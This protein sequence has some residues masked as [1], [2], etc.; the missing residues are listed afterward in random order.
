MKEITK[1]FSLALDWQPNDRAIGIVQP[2]QIGSGRRATTYT[3]DFETRHTTRKTLQLRELLALPQPVGLMVDWK[4]ASKSPN[5]LA[6]VIAQSLR[7][8]GGVIVLAAKLDYCWTIAELL[9]TQSNRIT[10]PSPEV[11]MVQK[12][13]TDEFAADFPLIEL[14]KYGVAVHHRGL[15]DEALR[16]IEW[17]F[18]K[19]DIK[20]L[21]AT[22]TVAQGM[23]FPV[24]SVVMASHQYFG[25]GYAVDMPPED[26]WNVAGRAGRV[27]QGSVGIVAFAATKDDKA[28]KLREFI[29]GEV[30]ALNST[31][32]A[33]VQEAMEKW[34][35][36]NLD[37][38]LFKE[39]KW[40]SFLQYLAHS[41]RQM[42]N[43]QEF[44]NRIEQILRGTLGFNTLR[45][46]HRGWA[47]KLISGVRV[48]A[49]R[50]AG[51]PLLLVDQTGFSLESVRLAMGKLHEME[52]GP[53]AW[54]GQQLF[55]RVSEDL[56]QMM[57][58]L[59]GVPELREGF[60]KLLHG[61]LQDG[62][63]LS[64][65][66]SDWVNG[67]SMVK[68]AEVYF[69]QG[70][71]ST[72][73]TRNKAYQ[74]CCRNVYGQLAQT[75]SWGLSALQTI[76]LAGKT[77]GMTEDQLARMRNIP[78]WV[79][80]GVNTDGALAMRMAG[81][82]REAATKLSR[83]IPTGKVSISG[84]REQLMSE[85]GAAWTRA[86]GNSGQTYFSIWRQLEGI[87]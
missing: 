86:L 5:K 74:E 84:I 10:T 26:F 35:T 48:Y 41:Y 30:G 44:A 11:V 6:A 71:P 73:E 72:P 7:S 67:A 64:S 18:E 58:V 40:S 61:K 25:S 70:L 14:L 55:T 27:D 17:L 47:D 19:G 3:L 80:Y 2:K 50:L 69:L 79:Y 57:G 38:L 46:H 65:F 20:V 13:L 82:P 1:T 42:E 78:A 81:V 53:Q 28:A 59:L 56:R 68:L 45:Q 85:K 22:T 8:R 75:V 87:P 39:P 49:E 34:P 29:D 4:E 9:K 63:T 62:N 60:S 43:G 23:N 21:V 12:F 83:V 51:S 76:S 66:V 54:D 24:A 15:S 16:L 37:S 52:I 32:V 31:L 36:L 33:L 77:E